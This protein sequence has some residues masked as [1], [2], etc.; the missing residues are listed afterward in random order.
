[1]DFGQ[2][3]RELGI[4]ESQ[5]QR[6]V[7]LL[8]DGNTVPFVT[9]YR[10]DQTG[11]LDE[12]QI[13]KIQDRVEKLRALM[14]RRQTIRKS[15]E[16]QEKLTEEL[17]S[18][19]DSV[20]TLKSLE[21]IYLPFKPRKRSHASV[22]KDRGLEPLAD[23]L[24]AG[25]PQ[26]SVEALAATFVN[27][28]LDLP[29]ADDVL[30]STKYIIAERF[31]EN[32]E[33][34]DAI[35]RTMWRDC[36]LR[37]QK[38]ELTDDD[39]DDE[40]EDGDNEDKDDSEID[41]VP[42]D[43]V[44][45][46]AVPADAVPADAVTADAVTADAVPA[47]AVPADAVPADAVP[48]DAVPADAVPADAVPADA[49]PADAVPADAVPADAVPADAVPADA[50]PADAVPAD[51]VPADAVPADAV[52]ADAVT[53]DA[54]PAD[55][56]PADAVPADAVPADA[57]PADAVPA[58]AVPADA[59]PADAVPA[60]AVPADAVPADAVP[61]DAVPADA[62]PA[63]A[64]PADAVTADAVAADAA[65]VSNTES[66]ETLATETLGAAK[67]AIEAKD[68]ATD[69][70]SKPVVAEKVTVKVSTASLKAGGAEST[71]PAETREMRR[72]ARREKR[73]K[74]R[75]KLVA[76][77]KDYFDYREKISKVPPHR[78]LAIN[79]GDRSRVLRVKL[80]LNT[81][82]IHEQAEQMLV[83]ADH[84]QRDFLLSCLRDGL[85][86]LALPSIEREVRRELTEQAESQAVSV[87]VRNL[88]NLLLQPPV[89]QHRILAIDPGYRS[90]CKLAMI[91]ECGKVLADDLIL[92]V[93]KK[94]DIPAAKTKLVEFAKQHH[95]TVIAIGNGAACR[96][97]EQLISELLAGDLKESDV[98]YVI[99]NEAGASY[100]STSSIG[101]EE[102]PNLDPVT[103]SAVSIGRRLLDPLSEL[104]K[105]NPANIGVGLYQHDVKAKHLR[106]SLDAVVESCVNFVG[107][108]VNTAS[109]ALLCYVSGLNQLSA[110]RLYE[111]RLEHGAFK[112]RDEI[113]KVSG[114]GEASYVQAAGFLKLTDGDN[115]LDATWIH[116]ESYAI[117][118]Q[119][120]E[121]LGIQLGQPVE[122]P[123]MAA[124][125]TELGVGEHLL[126]DILAALARPGHDPRQDL[127]APVFRRGIVK[128]E[129]LEPE[130][131]LEGTVLNVVD[132]GAFVDIGLSDSGLVHISRLANQYIKDPHEVVSVG[133]IL[134]VWVV[135]VDQKRRRVS[136]TALPPGTQRQTKPTRSRGRRPA[137]ASAEGSQQTTTATAT[138][139]PTQKRRPSGAPSRDKR[140]QR[141]Q[142]SKPPSPKHKSR[143]YVQKKKAS[144]PI[145]EEMT[146]GSEPMRSFSDLA[147][148][149]EKTQ[150]DSGPST[151]SPDSPNN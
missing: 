151:K 144:P 82:P 44:P 103:R 12:E 5:V 46:D 91:D 107:V 116:P 29:T 16:L 149:Y 147:Q 57:V 98:A 86:R 53:A 58:D 7:E 30:Q 114:I 142:R 84:P 1:M 17:A 54:V 125:A 131:E 145:T 139:A 27:P 48:A 150:D 129:D 89:R 47:D 105:I 28:E 109:P 39:A 50:V 60:D 110:R 62:V 95:A 33:L 61:A 92:I 118:E 59:V 32:V 64:V 113:L 146:E 97:A 143:E 18:Q 14:E 21:D 65:A 22:A 79:R 6:T 9:R 124:L 4:H 132:F 42:A 122:K 111:H 74:K 87:F 76:A 128:L 126:T 40:D 136:L 138:A 25:Q 148:F 83:P 130:M 8:D 140:N 37:S 43:A 19:I 2:V 69:A 141:D 134:K 10:K 119:V 117:A 41:A 75:E 102:L 11:A 133:D 81:G 100:Y 71:P 51:A 45:A 120:I 70:T 49:V 104:V 94:A 68:N 137:K 80:E 90:G 72:V 112:S 34:R 13:R 56:V 127:P 121:K 20:T 23:K 101:R 26:E 135:E 67:P 24:Q 96:E 123:D 88:R 78:I 35:R 52:P 36:E 63:D 66:T 99:V 93:G 115:P 73:R 85:Q 108:D 38:M 3:A 106:D 15:I 55:A 31:A 77:F